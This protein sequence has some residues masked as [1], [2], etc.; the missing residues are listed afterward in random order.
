MRKDPSAKIQAPENF[1]HSMSKGHDIF[2]V[3]EGWRL[4]G[5][6]LLVLGYFLAVASSVFAAEP[7]TRNVLLV[8]IDGVRWQEVFR[9]AEEALINK[10]HGGVPD[11]MLAA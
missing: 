9:G 4:S 11:N 10:E 3:F 2:S 8:T 5:A 6:W 1:Q 7:K